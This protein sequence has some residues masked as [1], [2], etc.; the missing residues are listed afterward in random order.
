MVPALFP[1]APAASTLAA[2]GLVLVMFFNWLVSVIPLWV[3][4][5][6]LGS[7]A[8]LIKTALVSLAGGAIE[9]AAGLYVLYSFGAYA[10]VLAAYLVWVLIMMVA[11][12]LSFVRALIATVLPLLL[13]IGLAFL[14]GFGAYL[15]YLG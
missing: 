5:K 8:G 12:E 10:G 15:F 4:L 3:S 6:I 13:V 1:A 2:S 7:D 9:L 11:F 14:T